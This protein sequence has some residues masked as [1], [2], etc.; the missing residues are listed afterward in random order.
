[1]WRRSPWLLTLRVASIVF[2][3]LLGYSGTTTDQLCSDWYG[4]VLTPVRF[5][6]SKR[7]LFGMGWMLQLIDEP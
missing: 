6:A 4:I 5:A 1:L 2:T 3:A 7:G